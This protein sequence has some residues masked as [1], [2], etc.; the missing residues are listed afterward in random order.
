MALSKLEDYENASL[1]YEKGIA[2][3]ATDHMS[4]L[5]YA[6]ALMKQGQRDRAGDMVR[7]ARTLF[8]ALE[9]KQRTSDPSVEPLLRDLEQQLGT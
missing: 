3:D 6:V 2:L 1:S 5:N 9:E 8:N 7:A 4:H